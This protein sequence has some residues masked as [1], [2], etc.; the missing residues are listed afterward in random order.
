MGKL[1]KLEI[2]ICMLVSRF[3]LEVSRASSCYL[4]LKLYSWYVFTPCLQGWKLQ[5]MRIRNTACELCCK[6]DGYEYI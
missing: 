1:L 3:G 5:E 6:P 2:C 4:M